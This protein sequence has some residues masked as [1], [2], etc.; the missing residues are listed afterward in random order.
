MSR[1]EVPSHKVIVIHGLLI[2]E[3]GFLW[4]FVDVANEVAGLFMILSGLD[5][6]TSQVFFLLLNFVAPTT[7]ALFLVI[8]SAV[9]ADL[10]SYLM[11]DMN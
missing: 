5:F 8:V 2:L 1:V 9:F 11:S 4:R 6:A 7:S 10:L 3:L